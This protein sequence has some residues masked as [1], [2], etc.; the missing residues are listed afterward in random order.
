VS[1]QLPISEAI[2]AS[3]VAVIVQF[4]NW[5][6]NRDKSR[7]YAQGAVDRAMKG[8][9]DGVSKQLERTDQRLADM[10]AQ[11]AECE[12]RLDISESERRQ[13]RA[14]IDE[15]MSERIAYP[16]ERAPR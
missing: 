15:L 4:L 3:A 14:K 10:E 16:G 2:T 5:L 12:R 1:A 11:H 9:L 8:A 7:A 13:M 6:S